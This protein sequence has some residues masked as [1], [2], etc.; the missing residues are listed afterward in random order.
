MKELFDDYAKIAWV[1][2]NRGEPEAVLRFSE[3]NEAKSSLEKALEAN[4][5]QLEV[6]GAKLECKV[7]EE[8]EEEEF[9]KNSVVPQIDGKDR[10]NN[11][12]KRNTG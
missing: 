11:K 2:Y 4:K 7:L 3:E 9:F 6:N 5:G 12:R 8:E 10:N 1:Y